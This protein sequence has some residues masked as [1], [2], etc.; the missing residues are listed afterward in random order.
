M[1]WTTPAKKKN[2]DPK[3]QMALQ[4]GRWDPEREEVEKAREGQQAFRTTMRVD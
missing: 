3:N 4:R 1:P 2:P